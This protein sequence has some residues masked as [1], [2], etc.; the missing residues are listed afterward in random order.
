MEDPPRH[1]PGIR[2]FFHW[3]ESTG[4]SASLQ[5]PKREMITQ[6][7]WSHLKGYSANNLSKFC[8]YPAVDGKCFGNMIYLAL[9]VNLIK[10]VKVVFDQ[11]LEKYKIWPFSMRSLV[12]AGLKLCPG[13]QTFRNVFSTK[14]SMWMSPDPWNVSIIPSLELN[15]RSS[16]NSV[17]ATWDLWFGT[18]SF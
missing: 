13:K 3:T 1:P 5:L 10:L 18:L 15:V 14:Q 11:T 8:Y 6:S 16:W 7:Q 12:E 17:N 4:I 9:P 2:W